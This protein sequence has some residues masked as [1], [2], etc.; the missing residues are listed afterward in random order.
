MATS[1]SAVEAQAVTDGITRDQIADRANQLVP[2][3]AVVTSNNARDQVY[4][5][6]NTLAKAETNSNP[7]LNRIQEQ[8]FSLSKAINEAGGSLSPDE[9]KAYDSIASLTGQSMGATA[10][11]RSALDSKQYKTAVDGASQYT[12]LESQRANTLNQ[13]YSSLAQRSSDI[14]TLTKLFAPS[15]EEA[16]T[17]KDVNSTKAKLRGNEASAIAGQVTAEGQPIAMPFITGQQAQ[18]QKLADLKRI[19]L[20]NELAAYADVLN[21]QTATRQQKLDAAKFAFDA[22]R[23]TTLDSITLYKEM[24]PQNIATNV[25][26]QTG[27][28]TVVMRNPL[29]GE[30]SKQNLGQVATPQRQVDNIKLAQEA[31]VNRPFFSRD[32][33]TIINTQ[34]GREY[35]SPEQ[36]FADGGSFDS[37]WMDNN[38]QFGVQSLQQQQLDIQRQ[39]LAGTKYQ[40]VINPITGEQTIFDPKLGRFT[41]VPGLG[42][43]E[44]SAQPY[45]GLGPKLYDAGA[46]IATKFKTEKVVENFN[47]INEAKAFVDSLPTDSNSPADDQGLLYAFAKAMDPNSVVRE[48]EY[49]T[50]QKYAQSWLETFGFNAK[51]IVDNGEFLTPEAR[52]NLKGTIDKKFQAS[53]QNYQNVASEYSRRIDQATGKSGV[54]GLFITDYSQAFNNGLDDIWKNTSNEVPSVDIDKAIRSGGLTFDSPLSSNTSAT[55][56]RTLASMA[57]LKFPPGSIGGQCGDFCR[58]IAT[59]FGLTYPSLGD[60]LTSKTNAVQKYGTPT[61]NAGIGSVIVTRENPTY[62]HVA[63]IVGKNS[64]GFLVAES[65]FKQSNKVSYGRVIPYNSSQIVGVIN[66][67]LK[68]LA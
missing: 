45:F 16:Q 6:A 34:S 55:G 17:M 28:M 13:L 18:I 46:A 66:P 48:G 29:T 49:A 14:Q 21:S 43:S 5:T 19:G 24:A 7:S 64:Q 60:S 50:V 33:K 12:T 51:R 4:K 42:N 57:S 1:L 8:V 54:G 32:G 53:F 61:A 9:Q 27:E 44:T 3:K 65:N 36:F 10:G 62:G 37:K 67:S 23:Q 38:V 41:S 26:A 39:Q 31:G 35:S 40:A 22:N 15:D 47:V 11:V 58:K 52:M 63:W 68:Q 30:L 59:S 20:S 56:G 25:D 2:P